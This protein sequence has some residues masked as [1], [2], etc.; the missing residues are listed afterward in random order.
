M[1]RSF[2]CFS[3][4]IAFAA[5]ASPVSFATAADW[6]RFRGPNGSGV[7][8][9]TTPTPVTWSPT[10]NLKWKIELPGPGSSSPIILGE[11]IF[12]TS[13]SGYG[14]DRSNRGGK[15]E[16]LKR[17]LTC[18]DRQ[19]GKTIW[20]KTVNAVLPE[21][22][23]GGMFAEHGYTTHT[24]ATDGE[25]VYVFFGKTGALAF[26]LDGNQLWQTPCGTDSNRMNWGSSSSPILYKNLVIITASMESQTI[27]ALD[28]TN[29]KEVWHTTADAFGDTWGTPILVDA[30]D[31]RT[32][33]VIG[34][35][36][37]I[38]V[39]NPYTGKLRWF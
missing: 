22:N 14:T 35:T 33:L 25:R 28:K 37:E 27:Y 19:T 39:F 10:E 23:Y 9:D 18:L 2:V 11:K 30:G 6:T 3:W 36:D 16:D 21:D 13:W 26:D 12:I 31:I 7:S 17:H 38:W 29:G 32:D 24:P 4:V 8:T 5:L 15:Q 1:R 20:D 34:V